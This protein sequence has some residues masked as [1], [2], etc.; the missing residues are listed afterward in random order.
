MLRMTMTRAVIPLEAVLT[1]QLAIGI[2]GFVLE[3]RMLNRRAGLALALSVA[4]PFGS[5]AMARE[6]SIEIIEAS[7][8]TIGHPDKLDIAA[9]LSALCDGAGEHCDVYCSET[10]FGRYRLGRKPICRVTFRCPDGSV[11]SFE[12]AREEPIL[13]RCPISPQPVAAIDQL[14]PLTYTPPGR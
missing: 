5:V 6:N 9:R 12:A 8:G 14:E 13:L 4:L 11:R 10:S 3:G 1:F 2:Y 7:F